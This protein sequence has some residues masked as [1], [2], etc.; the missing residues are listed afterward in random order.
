MDDPSLTFHQLEKEIGYRFRNQDL[1]KQALT[2]SSIAYEKNSAPFDN[3]RLEFLGDAVLQLVITEHIFTLF[4]YFHEGELTKIRTGLVSGSALKAYALRLQLGQHLIMG[5]G[6]EANGGRKRSSILADSFEALIGAMFLDGGI[7]PVKK[8]LLQQTKEHLKHVIKKPTEINPKGH[9]QEL[10]QSS[11]AGAPVYELVQESGAAHS[12]NF[13][14]R[15]LWNGRE[16]GIGEGRS[17]KAAE[18][19]AATEALKNQNG[20]LNNLEANTPNE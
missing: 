15:V 19:A 12:K 3:E 20:L 13:H 18:I 5:R 9:L 7:K 14:C 16:L 17:K 11:T 2:H 4:P 10:L 1:L 8:F 6:E